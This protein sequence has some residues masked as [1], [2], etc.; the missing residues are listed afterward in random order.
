MPFVPEP[1]VDSVVMSWEDYADNFGDARVWINAIVN[2]DVVTASIERE[3]LVRPVLGG[4][5]VN[6]V[7]SS[8]QAV[9][10]DFY[11]IGSTEAT[12]DSEWGAKPE[13]VTMTKEQA[14]P[15]EG[16]HILTPFGRTIHLPY[17][18]AVSVV[19]TFDAHAAA[20][21]LVEYPD[22]A[23]GAGNVVGSFFL[24]HYDRQSGDVTERAAHSVYAGTIVGFG[25]TTNKVQMFATFSADDGTHDLVLAFR[26]DDDVDSDVYQ[27]DVTRV[28]FQ[29]EVL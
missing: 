6:G 23:G 2:A 28:T 4:L 3:H 8:F 21:S 9:Y 27:I 10:H 24:Y 15:D 13:R 14:R 16:V 11:A 19:C 17:D 5:P 29:I 18:S 25:T 12:R 26:F 20:D 7:W 1:L 22:G